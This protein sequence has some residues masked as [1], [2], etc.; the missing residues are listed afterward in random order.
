MAVPLT[1]SSVPAQTPWAQYVASTGQAVF[2][3]PFEIT[4]DSDL[5]VLVNGVQQPVDGGYTLTG[6]GA[7]G[8]GNVNFAVG[9]VQGT[10][11]TLYRNIS[12]AR[13]TQLAQ[14]GTFFSANFNDEFN[15][16]YLIMQQLQQ[17]LL[18]GGNQAFALMVPN[19][20]SPAPTTLLT[21]ASY[22]GKYLSFDGNGNPIPA[23]LTSSGALT[24]P[25]VATVL[26]GSP[27]NLPIP[28]SAAETAASVVPVNLYYPVG[29]VDRYGTNTTPGT[30]SM[31]T[32]I[33]N[34][35]AVIVQQGG[36]AVV[37]KDGADYFVGNF[38]TGFQP[39]GVFN[40]V[41][42]SNITFRG[43]GRIVSNTSSNALPYIFYLTDCNQITFDG[44]RFFDMGYDPTVTFQGPIGIVATST[45]TTDSGGYSLRDVRG[46][47]IITPFLVAPG[48]STGRVR[49]VNFQN[50]KTDNCFYGAAFQE[51]GD[52]VTGSIVVN[53][54][55]RA[56]FVY[57]VHGHNITLNIWHDATSQGANAV[58][59]I[60][61][62][63]NDTSGIKIRGSFHGSLV[64]YG[65]LFNFESQM[66]TGTAG[67]TQYGAITGGSLYTSGWYANVPMTGGTGTGATAT[68]EI[69]G[70]V[71]VGIWPCARGKGYLTTDTLSC[72]AASVGGTGSGFSVAIT[73]VGATI[74]DVDI[75]IDLTGA[76]VVDP[77]VSGVTP[78]PVQ[79]RSYTQGGV[80]NVTTT[81]VYDGITIRGNLGD[82][83]FAQPGQTPQPIN[84]A[85]TQ[86]GIPGRL[87]LGGDFFGNFGGQPQWYPG[88]TVRT[89][90][91]TEV[92]TKLGDLT[93]A[94]VA[95]DMSK[96]DGQVFGLRVVI[97]ATKNWN[98]G[99][100]ITD[101]EF[102]LTGH[103]VFSNTP[104]IDTTTSGF[105]STHGT[106]T[107]PSFG[108]SGSNITVS[109]T[110]YNTAASYLKMSVQSLGRFT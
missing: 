33:T 30:T 58:I 36:G 48:T 60:K 5:V 17:S 82:W 71:V 45:L 99:S 51:N 32:A 38:S 46:Q 7:S 106:A 1:L 75:D 54:P 98:S 22:A 89:T 57:G 79:F 95:I 35:I 8:G 77:T 13:L 65:S 42:S 27:Q 11:I 83:S 84:I 80:L 74:S 39:Q 63:N 93:A 19:S 81:D 76:P 90:A 37:F 100:D 9:Q 40:I 70:G 20:N 97:H 103:K 88:F 52:A 55:V 104:T 29:Y 72:A 14:N 85:S 21:P 62:Y 12:I 47:N 101:A 28:V 67:I 18:P 66:T 64:Q 31:V 110:N 34:A 6:Q 91:D 43:R 102:I 16:I 4:Q 78:F 86:L 69:V 59:D 92:Y 53:N 109:F 105:S 10:V 25:I 44:L 49:G 107:T 96:Y 61:R 87:S 73:S 24:G 26:N 108:V 41:Q 2:P 56:Y 3:Y 23:A 94:A 68:I 15:R 50:V